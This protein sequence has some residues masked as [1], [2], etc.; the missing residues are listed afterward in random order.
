M[1]GRVKSRKALVL[2]LALFHFALVL[3]F[4]VLGVYAPGIMT[5]SIGGDS[6]FTIGIVF[7]LGIVLS[8]IGSAFYYSGRISQEDRSRAGVSGQGATEGK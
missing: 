6:V 2:K 7:A 5:R 8:V 3:L 4:D 1:A